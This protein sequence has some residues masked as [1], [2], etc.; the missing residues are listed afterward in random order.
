MMFA[1]ILLT[2]NACK[3]PCKD[4]ACLNGGACVDGTCVCA[5]GYTGAD[6]S[7]APD[8]CAGIVCQN[9]GSCV[10]GN[11]VC[12]NG[13][14]GVNCETPPDPCAG[15]TCLNGGVCVNGVCDCTQEW[16]G[17]NC[18]DPATPIRFIVNRIEIHDFPAVDQYGAPWDANSG[19]DI[20]VFASESPV[21]F[22]NLGFTTFVYENVNAN[23]QDPLIYTAGLPLTI[24]NIATKQF[25]VG[26]LD[27]DGILGE[28]VMIYFDPINFSNT[29]FY[30]G[31]TFWIRNTDYNIDIRLVGFYEY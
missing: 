28:T 19:P 25:A 24:N 7:T 14:T 27:D 12:A 10:N 2:L 29:T 17:P 13:Y 3:D 1:L 23:N 18:S 16:T 20:S 4:I 30:I 22:E 8:P 31:D 21:D 26:L 15:V 6:C 9:G 11:C 5:N